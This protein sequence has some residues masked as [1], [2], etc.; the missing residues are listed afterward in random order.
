MK[1]GAGMTGVKHCENV[2]G[3]EVEDLKKE[4]NITH[5]PSKF[6]FLREHNGY[7]KGQMHLVMGI[8]GGGKST[9]IRSLLLDV[10]G[11]IEKKVLVWLSEET[12]NAF[13]VEIS[14]TGVFDDESEPMN[15]VSIYSEIEQD[16]DAKAICI[17][18]QNLI[19]SG[20]YDFIIYD[21]ITTSKLYEGNKPKQQGE[22]AMWFKKQIAEADIPALVVAHTKADVTENINRI[23]NDNDIRGG[24]GIVNL[25]PFIYIL[26]RFREGTSIFPTITIQKARGTNVK[27]TIYLLN[28]TSRYYIN[29]GDKK[30][31]FNI[32][33]DAFA[34]RNKLSEKKSK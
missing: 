34:S 14:K 8:S 28:Y 16:K 19:K 24:K 23:I 15:K 10:L 27:D 9:L 11:S 20:E 7:K 6:N 22:F 12:I 18:M 3:M 30:I 31:S 1:I 33:S 5:Y 32:F 2:S 29:A 26:Q 17:D 25:S 4:S 13:M 21:N